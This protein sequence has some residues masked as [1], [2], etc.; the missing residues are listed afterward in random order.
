MFTNRFETSSFMRGSKASNSKENSCIKKI[1]EEN[2]IVEEI[3]NNDSV[4]GNLH[5]HNQSLLFLH[6]FSLYFL[7]SLHRL[8]FFEF[9][10]TF[11]IAVDSRRLLIVIYFK[12]VTSTLFGKAPTCWIKHS[13]IYKAINPPKLF[14]SIRDI[15]D[16]LAQLFQEEVSHVHTII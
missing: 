16:I 10:L 7:S 12:M 15:L 11:E 9:F 3:N 14:Q 4:V 8:L 5:I 2:V 6:L 13:I 1:L